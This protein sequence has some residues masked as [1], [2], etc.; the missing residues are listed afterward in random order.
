MPET[1]QK[2]VG[3]DRDMREVMTKGGDVKNILK[4]CTIDGMFKKLEKIEGELKIC[5]K[6]LNEFLDSKRKAFPRFYFVSVNDLLDILSNGNS[7]M[8][9]NKH[10]TKIFQAIEK[11]HMK[12][13]GERPVVEGMKAGVGKEEVELVEP[14]KLNGKVENYLH[15]IIN[16]IINTMHSITSKSFQNH[17][18]YE[19]R[20]WINMDPAQITL[21]VNNTIM[22]THVEGCFK[23]ISDGSNVNALK[24][25]YKTSV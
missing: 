18:K 23:K 25:Y 16:A 12:E 9:V 3:I 2:F 17:P 15:D 5:E 10:T 13:A 14:L 22:T 21:V 1:S 20:E 11:F 4:F 19:R 8:K 6:A 24:E 7:P